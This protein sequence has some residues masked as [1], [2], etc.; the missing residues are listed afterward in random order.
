MQNSTPSHVHVCARRIPIC[1]PSMDADLRTFVI[2][3]APSVFHSV[4]IQAAAPLLKSNARLLSC[5]LVIFH[6][7]PLRNAV[8][9]PEGY[10][11]YPRPSLLN[12]Q[13]AAK[14]DGR[15]EG[16]EKGKKKGHFVFELQQRGGFPVDHRP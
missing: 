15:G 10:M 2:T 11:E 4:P 12:P 16:C 8:Q 14:N 1:T 3:I 7:I 9:R 5:Y 13:H 6:C